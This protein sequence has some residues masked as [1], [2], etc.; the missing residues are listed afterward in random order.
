MSYLVSS[1]EEEFDT[2]EVGDSD[3]DRDESLYINNKDGLRDKLEDFR[4]PVGL[5]WLETQVLDATKSQTIDDIHDDLERELAFYNQALEAARQAVKKFNE[6][7]ANWLRPADYYAEMVKSDQHMV[8]VKEQLLHE[9][10][11]IEA[12]EQRRK[13]R[14]SRKFQKQLQAA[15]RQERETLK[16][17][18]I[19]AGTRLRKK[20]KEMGYQGDFNLDVELEAL[21][22]EDNWERG[23]HKGRLE[24]SKKRQYRDAKYGYGGRMWK[25]KR[26]DAESAGDMSMFKGARFAEREDGRRKKQNRSKRPGKARRAAMRSKAASR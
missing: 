8:K 14:E 18:R 22:Q 25:K 10:K 21:E 24:P 23:K 20:R 6:A 16:K 12:S 4:W 17:R 26:N 7:G 15:K 5:P 13:A 3:S 2:E 1:D 9:Q 11:R 19:E